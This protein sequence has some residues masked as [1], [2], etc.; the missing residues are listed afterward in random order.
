M[1]PDVIYLRRGHIMGHYGIS[2]DEFD[3]LVTAGVFVPHYL[4]VPSAEK[5][6]LWRRRRLPKIKRA[7]FLRADVLAAE[8]AHRIAG[9]KVA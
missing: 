4:P 3:D 6:P 7:V 1:L 2:R 5:L 9:P 8:K